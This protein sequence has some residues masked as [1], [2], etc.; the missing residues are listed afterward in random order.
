MENIIAVGVGGCLG[1]ILRYL[2]S[3]GTAGW[4]NRFPL[5][6]A[7]V[8]ILGGFIM[9]LLMGL[10]TIKAINLS[11]NWRL[12]LTTGL[13]G[14]LTTFSTFSFETILLFDTGDYLMAFL[15]IVLNLGPSLLFCFAGYSLAKVV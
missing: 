1:A 8:N 7:I 4:I 15:N 12:F 5:G 11:Q 9:G 6:T 3:Q 2:I 10:F 14:G 13:L